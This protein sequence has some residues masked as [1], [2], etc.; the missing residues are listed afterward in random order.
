M[1]REYCAAVG[2]A[3]VAFLSTVLA[4][5]LKPIPVTVHNFIRAETD[6]YFGKMP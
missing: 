2:I 4:Q 1:M 5:N 3:S 6:L